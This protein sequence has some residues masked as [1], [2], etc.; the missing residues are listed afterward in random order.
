MTKK[1]FLLCAILVSFP[2]SMAHAEQKADPLASVA[3]NPSGQAPAPFRTLLD[4]DSNYVRGDFNDNKILD[5]WDVVQ[6]I[7]CV[8]LS[9]GGPACIICKGD[10]TCDNLLTPVDVVR[11][12]ILS[13]FEP[14][15]DIRC[16]PV[17]VP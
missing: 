4:C 12:L 7:N 13:Y 2:A 6:L 15:R 1:L 9:S 17:V 16:G 8:F 11:I 5:T 3:R 10:L 14:Q